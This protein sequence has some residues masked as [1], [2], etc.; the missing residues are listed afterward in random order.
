MPSPLP[1]PSMPTLLTAVNCTV[2]VHLVVGSNLLAGAR[3]SRSLE[4]GAKVI[5]I[6]PET[7]ALPQGVRKR[8]DDGEV[9][10]IRREF[11]AEDLTTLG[12]EE[13]DHVV[14]LVFVTLPVGCAQGSI[15]PLCM[16]VVVVVVVLVGRLLTSLCCS[17]IYLEAM[18]TR[19][20]TRQRCG[21]AR[22]MHLHAAVDT[23]R[24]RAAGGRDDER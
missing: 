21:R 11:C 15:H 13:V 9:Q 12:R 14:D 5:L 4:V 23:P 10:W 17:A 6:A 20:D 1:P 7:E 16:V 3:C 2:Q 24:W 8:V 18:Q 19:A 22:A